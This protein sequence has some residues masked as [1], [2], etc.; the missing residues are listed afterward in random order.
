MIP[1]ALRREQ[2]FYSYTEELGSKAEAQTEELNPQ[3]EQVPS[4]G[5]TV[6]GQACWSPSLPLCASNL[7]E[8][9][10]EHWKGQGLCILV[11]SLLM[12]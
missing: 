4:P 1:G 7:S 11:R 10:A 2:G 3:S 6:E 9:A 8:D 5:D 12:V